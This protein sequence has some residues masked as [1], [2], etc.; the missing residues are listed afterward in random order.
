MHDFAFTS[1]LS[2]KVIDFLAGPRLWV[3]RSSYPDFMDWL[4]KVSIEI[5][6]RT[7]R[8]IV[9]YYDRK[10]VGAAIYQKHK[11]WPQFLELKNITI[12]PEVSRR[13]IASFL[14]RN[15]E[16][17][18]RGHFSHVICDA[19]KDNANIRQFLTSNKYQIVGNVDLYGL[20]AGPDT[21]YLKELK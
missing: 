3:P 1:T 7:K 13:F 8:G 6:N 20:R 4:D 11:T 2:S 9:C 14:V 12:S 16:A 18:A 19:K 10:M 5:R 15:I 21:V 17:E